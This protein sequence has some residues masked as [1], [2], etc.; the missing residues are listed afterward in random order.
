MGDDVLLI[1][2]QAERQS[3][4][5]SVGR[6]DLKIRGEEEKRERKIYIGGALVLTCDDK[7]LGTLVFY[8]LP[9]NKVSNLGRPTHPFGLKCS[10]AKVGANYYMIFFLASSLECESLSFWMENTV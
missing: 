2:P 4:D 10:Y 5:F 3:C 7:V 6:T 9:L 1:S 8:N